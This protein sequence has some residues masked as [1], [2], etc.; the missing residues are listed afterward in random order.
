MS[1]TTPVLDSRDESA[2][3]LRNA[4]TDEIRATFAL[5]QAHRWTSSMQDASR[6]I[7]A[8]ERLRTAVLETRQELFDAMWIDLHKS[9]TEA[10]MSEIHPVLVEIGHTIRHLRG[11]MRPKRVRA[12]LS[13]LGT[14]A[15]IR[16]EA[17][18]VV[19]VIAPWNYPFNLLINPLVA[20]I[21]AGNTVIAKPSEKT[22]NVSRY[23]GRL[24]SK[25][26]AAEE[27]AV[28][29]G[30]AEVSKTLLTLPFDHIFF[31][32]STMLGRIVMEAASKNLTPVTLELGGKS[33][34]I[35]DASADLDAAADRVAWGRFINAGQTCIA[36]DYVLVHD[37][38]QKA[39]VDRCRDAIGRMYGATD[40]DRQRT[41]DYCRIVD[42][43]AFERLS[44]LIDDAIG[45][46][47]VVAVG[48][49]RDAAE[50][51][52]AP[53]I[54]TN[55]PVEADVMR[56]EIF[57]PILPVF[58]FRSIDEAIATVR[59]R[60]KP[61]AMY[62][63]ARDRGVAKH[64]IGSTTAGGTVVNNTVIHFVHPNLPFGGIGESGLGSYHGEAGFRTFS[65]ERAVLR[66]GWPA[67][68]S[69]FYPPYTEKARKMV[70]AATKWF[71]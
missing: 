5:Q 10:E 35:V 29:E 4:S 11:W 19:L 66:Q 14:H 18:G 30:D 71:S 70:G 41:G 25:V 50:R 42:S 13:L 39:F 28:F 58:T 59:T 12:P 7:A 46:G 9:A 8:L 45:R 36:P 1:T 6:R 49:Q 23:I 22:P 51:F 64:V 31:T 17:K 55:V 68:F 40:A 38:V 24:I 3:V 53:T 32:G 61:L 56:D 34:V 37:S 60:P 33:P 21:S 20:A 16:S 2:T 47:A 63:F 52:I 44:G 57:G 62:I 67:L 26:F 27:V 48:G 69:S 15:E 65:H 43:A 54:L